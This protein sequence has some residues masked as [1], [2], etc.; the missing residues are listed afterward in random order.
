MNPPAEDPPNLALGGPEMR[1]PVTGR[2]VPGHPRLGGRPRRPDLYTVAAE[3]AAAEGVDL[4]QE[5]WGVVK[6]LLAAAKGGDVQAA[7]LVLDR[8]SDADPIDV[9][10]RTDTLTDVERAARLE[11]ILR[12]GA[13]R[14]AIQNGGAE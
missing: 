6:Q 2:F 3:R 4:A 9:N 11:A 8:L 12:V 13:G 10:L 5:L 14:R 7:R 1:D